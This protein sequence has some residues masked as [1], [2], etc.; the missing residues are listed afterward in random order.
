LSVHLTDKAHY[1][2]ALL[3]ATGSQT[4][5]EVLQAL[6]RERGMTLTAGCVNLCFRFG[7]DRLA[8]ALQA[9]RRD[10]APR[11]PELW[12]EVLLGHAKLDATALITQRS[13]RSNAAEFPLFRNGALASLAAAAL[14]VLLT[15]RPL[16]NPGS[17]W[18]APSKAVADSMSAPTRQPSCSGGDSKPQRSKPYA[19]QRARWRGYCR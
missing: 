5:L 15:L 6:A 9:V 19:C 8:P 3:F 16:E 14:P 17:F 18:G 10:P 2:A 7:G 11:R 12:I 1:G 4:H 13:G